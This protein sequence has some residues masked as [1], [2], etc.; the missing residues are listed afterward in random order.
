MAKRLVIRSADNESGYEDEQGREWQ[1][2][3]VLEWPVY[4]GDETKIPTVACE[5]P[6]GCKGTFRFT[7]WY[8]TERDLHVCSRHIRYE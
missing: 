4:D 3:N 8:D 5:W 7:G 1:R 2:I 6:E